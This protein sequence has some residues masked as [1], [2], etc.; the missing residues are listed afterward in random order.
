LPATPQL[1]AIFLRR[2]PYS[3]HPDCQAGS[4]SAL[5]YWK[6][7]WKAGCNDLVDRTVTGRSTAN[8]DPRKYCAIARAIPI[9]SP[10]RTAA[11]S[12]SMTRAS[13]SNGR[14]AASRSGAIRGDD[15]RYSRVHPPLPDACVTTGFHHIRYD[16]ADR[17]NANIARI[18]EP[19]AV[20]PMPIDIKAATTKPQQLQAPGIPAHAAAAACASSRPSR[21]GNGPSTAERHFREIRIDTS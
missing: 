2:Q 6:V 13:P 12:R 10:S 14:I 21:R 20:P 19:L 8:R 11:W 1:A 18:R 5:F 17:S 15:T 9:A 7:Y 4:L 16:D 3:R